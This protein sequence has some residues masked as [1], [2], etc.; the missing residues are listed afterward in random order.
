MS[1]MISNVISCCFA[2]LATSQGGSDWSHLGLS[3]RQSAF[4][5]FLGWVVAALAVHSSGSQEG[6]ARIQVR[7]SRLLGPLRGAL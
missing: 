6:P 5:H 7:D 3:L 4:V 1:V 2:F